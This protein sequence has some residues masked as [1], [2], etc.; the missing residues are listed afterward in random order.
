MAG[1]E[2]DKSFPDNVKKLV[3]QVL[4]FGHRAMATVFDVFILHKDPH[5]ARQAA[6]AAFA[7]ADR[8]EGH[9]SRF[10]ENSDIAQIRNLTAG[11]S[12]CLGIDSFE[13]LKLSAGL[14]D[15][16]GG[17]FDVTV[18][19]LM[20]CWF[21]ENRNLRQPS[22]QQ[23]SSARKFVGCGL[24]KLDPQ[25]HTIEVLADNLMIDLGG[26][27]KGYTADK[28]GQL[29]T[30]WDITTTLISSGSSSVL[31]LEPPEKLPGWP[32]TLSNPQGKQQTLSRV[33]LK[34]R[35]LGGSGLQKGRHIIDPRSGRPVGG[36]IAAWSSASDAAT[37]DALS[38]AFMVMQPPEIEK[39]CRS[40]QDIGAM[41]VLEEN[42][43][44]GKTQRILRFGNWPD[45]LS[46]A[47]P[48]S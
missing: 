8:L 37:A 10:V 46:E 16:T 11:Q 44:K 34:N 3:P 32:V 9:L 24:F 7:E 25:Q 23:L 26:V 13:C 20:K 29:L 2:S 15:R 31:A 12:L 41:V 5:Y 30:D 18:G 21:D 38:T 1:A 33:Y 47:A 39:F 35:A 42:Q 17:A 27:G 6:E 28:M 36:R 14:C 45:S 43:P 22:A 48:D 40:F 4:R 19:S